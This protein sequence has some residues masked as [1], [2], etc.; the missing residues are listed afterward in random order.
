METFG[1]KKEKGHFAHFVQ[2]D[3][4]GMIAEHLTGRQVRFQ[5]AVF[6]FVEIAASVLNSLIIGT[7]SN[8]EVNAQET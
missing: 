1:V 4:H 3:R 6:V 8:D 5:S 7:F 2:R